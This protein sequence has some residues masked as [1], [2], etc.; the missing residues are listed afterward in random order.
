MTKTTTCVYHFLVLNWYIFLNCYIPH[1]GKD[2]EKLK[3]FHDGGRS[4]YLTLLNLLLQAIF[5]G[6][7]C[8]DDVLKRVI[9]RKDIKFVTPFRDLLFTTLAFPISTFVFLVFWTLFHY[10]RSLV[11]PKGLDDFFPA[12]VNHAMDPVA[13]H[14]DWKLGVPRV[15]LPQP[16]GYYSLLLSHLHPECRH[17]PVWREDQSLEMGC[18]SEA[19]DEEELTAHCFPRAMEE[20]T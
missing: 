15:C 18:H 8:L 13:L 6:V 2:E 17:L 5:F 3:E 19:M 7:A 4:K 20:E 9:G 11:Y 12:W 14:S 1:I 16:T 10:D